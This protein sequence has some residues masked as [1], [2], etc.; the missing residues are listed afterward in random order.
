MSAYVL[1]QKLFRSSII[2]AFERSKVKWMEQ[3]EMERKSGKSEDVYGEIASDIVAKDVKP[4]KNSD[5]IE[6]YGKFSHKVFAFIV[7]SRKIISF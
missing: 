4:P 1:H 7:D 5:M 6:L 3:K 2:E